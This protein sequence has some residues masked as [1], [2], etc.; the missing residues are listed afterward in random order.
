MICSNLFCHLV[1][2]CLTVAALLTG[3]RLD[4][5][6]AVTQVGTIQDPLIEESSGLQASRRFPGVFWTHNDKGNVPTL[7]AINRQGATIGRFAVTGEKIPDW[8]DIAL[9]N[10]GNIY[11]ADTGNNTHDRGTLAVHMVKEPNPRIPIT[12]RVVKSWKFKAPQ[13]D[14][15]GEAIFIHGPYCYIIG[16]VVNPG[17]APMYRFALADSGNTRLLKV[18]NITTAGRVTGADIS[19]DGQRLALVTEVGTHLFR[20]Q[21]NPIRA[22]MMMPSFNPLENPNCEGGTFAGNG[23]LVSAES[24]E[25]YLITDPLYKSW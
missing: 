19:R 8:E 5:Q 11:I 15:D 17:R 10:F 21:G 22:G 3:L 18:G 12:L 7:Y 13:E 14:L 20:I 23:F 9:D 25:L 24:R 6:A 16:K 1:P 4:A 2:S